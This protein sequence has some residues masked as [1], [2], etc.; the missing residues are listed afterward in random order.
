MPKYSLEL[1]E[2]AIVFLEEKASSG[3]FA[4][5][6]DYICNLLQGVMDCDWKQA[7]KEKVRE[8]ESEPATEMTADDWEHLRRRVY[9]RHPELAKPEPIVP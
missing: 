7:V 6:G 1:P 4:S 5:P 2:T 3:G 9:G 8:A